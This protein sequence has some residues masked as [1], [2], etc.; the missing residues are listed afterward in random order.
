M[1][2]E[3]NI[4]R[5]L[6]TRQIDEVLVCGESYSKDSTPLNYDWVMR[7]R[8]QCL[9]EKVSFLFKETGDKIIKDGKLYTIPYDKQKEQATK[10][11]L[12]KKFTKKQRQKEV[13]SVEQIKLDDILEDY[14]F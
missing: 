12:N 2:S 6:A 7:L 8:Q 9:D 13:N 4:Q 11:N 10:A 14:N 5:Y 1:L 3:L